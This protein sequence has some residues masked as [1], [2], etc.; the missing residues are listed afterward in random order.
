[1]LTPAELWEATGRDEIPEIFHVEDAPGAG[2][3]SR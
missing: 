3:C 1:M 2:S